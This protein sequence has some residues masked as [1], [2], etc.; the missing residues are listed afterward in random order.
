MK[1]RIAIAALAVAGMASSALALS[2]A[3]NQGNG[4]RA[5]LTHAVGPFVACLTSECQ[6]AMSSWPMAPITVWGPFT[7]IV[8]A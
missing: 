3:D 4:L 7:S 5:A 8:A 2:D 6:G 1:K